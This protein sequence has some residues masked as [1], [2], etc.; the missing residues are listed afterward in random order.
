MIIIH[1]STDPAQ[2]GLSH[3]AFYLG[4]KSHNICSSV[5]SNS[6]ELVQLLLSCLVAVFFSAEVSRFGFDGSVSS[7]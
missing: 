2:A 6:L 1:P 7:E 4:L 5:L 3:V